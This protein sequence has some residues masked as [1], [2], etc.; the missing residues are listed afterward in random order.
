MNILMLICWIAY[1]KDTI[2]MGKTKLK[3]H[4]I[5]DSIKII[6]T[7]G[8]LPGQDR[9]FVRQMKKPARNGFVLFEDLKNNILIVRTF[10]GEQ[11]EYST[12]EEID[13]DGWLLD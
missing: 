2:T 9:F 3:P 10:K 1:I 4:W 5:E 13:R 7:G 12:V 11:I 8:F 6:S